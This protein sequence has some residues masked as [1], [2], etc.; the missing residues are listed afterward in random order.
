GGGAARRLTFGGRDRYPIW[1]ADN[2]WVI[3]QSDRG[4]DNAIYRQRADGSGTAE[5]L[6]TAG[7][8]VTQFPET[9]APDGSLFLFNP[10]ESLPGTRTGAQTGRTKLMAYS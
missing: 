6:T 9:A 10:S 3:F 1:S 8:D 2:K 4:G 5:R 7:K